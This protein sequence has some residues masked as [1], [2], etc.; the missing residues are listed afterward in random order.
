[1]FTES[2]VVIPRG[3]LRDIV[4]SNLP[5]WDD[6]RLWVLAR[7]LSGFAETFSWY[8]VEVAPGGG[9]D[10]PDD[11]PDAESVLFVVGGRATLTVGDETHSLEPGSYAFVPPGTTWTL[12]SAGDGA[13]AEPLTF[14]WIRKAYERVEGIEVP[15][16]FVVH[17]D[18]R[19]AQPRPRTPRAW[20]PPRVVDP[21]DRRH[22]NHRNND[23]VEPRG[24]IPVPET[25]RMEHGR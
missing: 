6:T 20:G 4:T 21:H 3:C 15:E 7:P 25:P 23:G 19:A 2:Y 13:D 18:D 11:D 1:M 8:L 9:T 17:Q 22:H 5:F 10:R 24:A 16:P 14:H 12:R